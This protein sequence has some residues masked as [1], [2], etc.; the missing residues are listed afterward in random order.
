[1]GRL[2]EMIKVRDEEIKQL[3]ERANVPQVTVVSK[4]GQYSEED[5]QNIQRE[6]DKIKANKDRE[7][8]LLQVQIINHLL[9]IN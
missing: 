3:S 6:F 8:E 9:S 7:L 5:I 1:M 2:R 4:G